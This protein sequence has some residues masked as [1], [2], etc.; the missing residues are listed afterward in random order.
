[1][2]E[3]LNTNPIAWFIAASEIGFWVLIALGLTLRYV[4]RRTSAATVALAAIPVLDIVLVV[5]TALDLARG[6]E[7][8]NVH[9]LAG[10]YLG[11]SVAFGP[12]L[13]RWCDVRFA[14]RFADGPAP[15]KPAKGSRAKA[16]AAWQEWFRVLGAAAIASGVL[17]A[18]G[19]FFADDA[20]A[21]SLMK[22]A[23]ALWPLVLAWLFLGPLWE[24]GAAAFKQQDPY[25][26]SNELSEN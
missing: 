22:A 18:G 20:Y 23:T 8:H 17:V 16:R 24:S 6:A 13:V 4:T 19:L 14:H 11:F 12:W 9:Y 15:V 26:A 21:D 5:A 2:L 10:Y 25:G 3:Y 7:P 1:M